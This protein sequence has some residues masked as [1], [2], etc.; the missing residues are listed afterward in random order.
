M[1]SSRDLGEKI[2][3]L[4]RELVH[5]HIEETRAA[6]LAAVTR[7]VGASAKAEPVRAASKKQAP[8]KTGRR[9]APHEVGALAETLYKQVCAKPGESMLVFAAELGATARELHRPMMTL[10]R[11]GR[12]RAVGERHRTR[13]FPGLIAGASSRS[14]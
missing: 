7:A 3:K 5:A 4:V 1:N 11:A 14:D 2:E 10:K 9:R 6:V 8:R 13:Y 12:V